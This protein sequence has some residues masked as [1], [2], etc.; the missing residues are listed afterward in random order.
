MPVAK[1][2]L[3]EK[4]R[5]ITTFFKK[6]LIKMQ[7]KITFP[8]I[9]IYTN[10]LKELIGELGSNVMLPPPITQKTIKLGVKYS[11]DMM[12]F[13]FKVTLGSLLEAI[14]IAEKENIKL[15]SLGF[16]YNNTGKKACRFHHY[17][18]IQKRIVKDLGYDVDMILVQRKN[19][20]KSLK[21]IN[22]KNSYLKVLNL[23]W[24]KYKKAKQLEKEY[25]FFDW[26]DTKKIRIGIVGEWFTA[27]EGNINYNMFEKLK[28]MNVNVHQSDACTLTGF[29]KHQIGFEEIPRKYVKESRKYYGGDFQA[30]GNY[31]LY[32]MFF[33]K[34]KGFDGVIHLL[35]LSCSPESIVEMLMDLVSNK[36]DLP[37]YRFPIDEDVF[38]TGFDMR[39]NSIIRILERKKCG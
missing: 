8:R 34:D 1:G 7:Q 32:N 4:K 25:Y 2:D 23:F 3:N 16:G 19:I 38:K 30:H 36:L 26:N 20:F 29:L 28:S 27:I 37:V 18:E 24:Q 9:G 22:K 14:N 5:M 21:K 35:P 33:Y 15:T 6:Y 10:L 11:S 39:I 13:P 17:F 31:S 12:C